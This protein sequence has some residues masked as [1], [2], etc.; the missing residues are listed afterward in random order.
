M[1]KQL[2]KLHVWSL[3]YLIAKK[4]LILQVIMS[5]SPKS[6]Q[7]SLLNHIVKPFINTF[8]KTWWKIVL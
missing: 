3:Q 8:V 1:N 2:G 4:K 5:C 6:K 7:L